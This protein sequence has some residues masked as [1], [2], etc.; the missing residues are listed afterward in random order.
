MYRNNQ[1]LKQQLKRSGLT[2][3]QRSPPFVLTIKEICKHHNKTITR[4]CLETRPDTRPPDVD[5]WAGADMRIYPLF[6]SC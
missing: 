2:L 5:G 6:D 1:N 4:N 3:M